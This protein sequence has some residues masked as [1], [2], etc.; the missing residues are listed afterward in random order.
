MRARRPVAL[1]GH[2]LLGLGLIGVSW[3]AGW[4]HV[5]P[6]AHLYFF[7]LWCG[8]ILTIDAVVLPRRGASLLRTNPWWV[9]RLFVS[10]AILWWFFELCNLRVQSW[11]YLLPAHESTAQFVVISTISFSTVLPAVFETA[12][13]FA[14]LLPARAQT[15]TDLV[16]PSPTQHKIMWWIGLV[17]LALPLALP[18]VFYPLIWGCLVLLLDPV[19]ARLGL[20][21]LAVY[22]H[23]GR[24]RPLLLLGL[25]GIV[26]G[27]FWEMWN[28]LAFPKWAYTIPSM[29]MLPHLFE[30]PLP[31]YVGYIPFAWECF[32]VYYWLQGLGR[33][34]ND[35]LADLLQLPSAIGVL[36]GR[37]RRLPTH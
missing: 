6:L 37:T 24:G 30:M 33:S 22:L 35:H 1:A 13:L 18:T 5:T 7:P 20:P 27:F 25:A 34:S 32:V 10:S 19:N 16:S 29:A 36:S 9:I 2:G 8:Y 4:G 12:T 28:Y 26:C 11:R 14:T 23:N 31:G 3:V 15:A 17:Y 21:S